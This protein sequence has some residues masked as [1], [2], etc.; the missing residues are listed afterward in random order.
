M[1]LH[2]CIGFVV[3]LSAAGCSQSLFS[4]GA[5]HDPG[6][7]DSG[8]LSMPPDARAGEPDGGEDTLPDAGDPRAPDAG[9]SPDAAPSCP[10]PCLFDV[11][12]DF[13]LQQGGANGR[14]R[15]VELRPE[16]PPGEEY[17]E[18]APDPV[19][20]VGTGDPAPS[21]SLCDEAGPQP[22]CNELSG[23]IALRTP[24]DAPGNRFPALMWTAPA[25]GEYR[26]DGTLQVAPEVSPTQFALSISRGGGSA[27]IFSSLLSVTNDGLPLTVVTPLLAPGD[28]I[29]IDAKGVEQTASVGLLLVISPVN[30]REQSW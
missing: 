7:R 22:I 30:P 20:W 24:I 21:I 19:G 4:D 17:V 18:M 6:G 28:T 29:V 26:V 5:G 25:A 8:P 10:L 16:L 2:R 27:P 15:Y 13:A 14:W 23:T 12:A 9:S 11:F 1:A 3:L